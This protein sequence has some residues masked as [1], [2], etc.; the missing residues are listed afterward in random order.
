MAT[1]DSFGASR[2]KILF[3]PG[4]LT[5]SA[6][7]KQAL[8][9][10]LGSR[11]NE[12]IETVKDI[13]HRLAAMTGAPDDYVAV[14]MQGSGT[15]S[16]EAVVSSC[17]PVGGRVVVIVNGAYGKRI[18]Q[19][20]RVLEIDHTVVECPED[21]HPDLED[22]RKALKGP[23]VDLVAVVHC[24]T[25]TGIVN[26]IAEIGVLAHAAG[27][28]YFVDAMSSFGAIPIS[29]RD[30]HIDFLV[31]SANKCI[32]GV[33]GFGFVIAR[34]DAIAETEGYARSLSLDLFAQW[35]GLEQTGQF[36]FTPP[37]H[38]L[39]AF[40]QALLE[41]EAEGGV[42]G[43]GAR[44]RKN[45][46]TL[47]KGM[48]ALGFVE[49][50]PA[51]RQ[52]YIITSFRCPAHANFKFE[53]FYSA[54]SSKDYVIYP[55]KVSNADCFRIGNIGHIYENDVRNLLAAIAEVLRDMEVV[56]NT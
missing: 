45:Y 51:D 9:H 48:R 34:R 4:P 37:T 10:D 50:L 29:F 23:R 1:A 53:P 56:L 25:T 42:E 28:G 27:A 30:A 31:S 13:R 41:L 5:T 11:D 22:I 6:T 39:L 7:V 19:M 3:T 36:R 26:P 44:Y 40:H 52:G 32:E 2:D 17:V 12:F 24:E 46:D 54:L 49:Y 47:V 33:P 43:R 55:G 38:T 8:L 35:N 21:Q 15:F 18:V 20:L 14:L 16:I